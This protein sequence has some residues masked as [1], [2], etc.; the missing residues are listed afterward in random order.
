MTERLLDTKQEG[1][2]AGPIRQTSVSSDPELQHLVIDPSDRI[3]LLWKDVNYSIATQKGTMSILSDI[4][5]F[6]E[7]GHLT[8]IMGPSGSGKTTLLNVLA[9]RVPQQSKAS[10]EGEVHLKIGHRPLVNVN[11]LDMPLVS[12]YVEQHDALFALSTVRE[13]FDFVAKLR[14]FEL[15]REEQ[16]RRVEDV[17]AELGLTPAADT[18]VGS[19]MPG[20]RGVSGGER[21]RVG[22]GC[23]LLH[24]P[25]LL[26]LD[27]PTSGLD[28][29]Q[30]LQVMHTLKELASMG[31]TVVCSVHQPRSSIYSMFDK[32]VLLAGGRTVYCGPAGTEASGYFSGVGFPVP[33]SFNPADHFLDVIS[34]DQR[35]SE[36]EE[37]TRRVQMLQDAHANANTNSQP[38]GTRGEMAGGRETILAKIAELSQETDEEKGGKPA[39]STGAAMN[40]TVTAA[41]LS[42]GPDGARSMVP[43]QSPSS[44]GASGREPHQPTG[45]FKLAPLSVSLPLL[46]RRSW[47]ELTRDVFALGIKWAFNF[48]FTLMFGFVYF[49]MDFSETSLQDRTG[50]IFFLAMNQAFGATIGTAQAIPR[51]LRVVTRERAAKLYRVFP[52]WLSTF[53]CSLPLETLPQILFGVITYYMVN[54][55]HGVNHLFVFVAILLL[56][57]F[58]GIAI[59]MFLSSAITNV[60]AVP[61]VAPAVTIIFLMFSGFFLNEDSI[62]AVFSPLKYISFIRYAFQA[63]C[64]NELRDA[65]FCD[66]IPPGRPCIEGNDMLEGYLH[67]G[68]VKIWEN[69]IWL[70]VEIAG[71]NI[72]AFIVLCLRRPAFLSLQPPKPKEGRQGTEFASL[73]AI[74]GKRAEEM[75]RG[76]AGSNGKREGIS[77]SRD[78]E[79]AASEV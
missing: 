53:L 77:R 10:L 23:E 35:P 34:I 5:G 52:F 32:L 78:G 17:I 38:G 25:R 30:A 9:G 65:K 70:A 21:K 27:E 18:R 40:R 72:L 51:Q 57:N 79:V 68:N 69:A 6:A 36:K 54:L 62:P 49:R 55:R 76:E 75:S 20:Q 61:Q 2:S 13:T 29:F 37:T 45:T 26:F 46:L 11:D 63:L 24:R 22:L 44:S 14:L 3:S 8:A 12:A 56:E 28:S 42:G 48:F 64:V 60:E 41:S 15:P 31:H 66:G 50:I 73:A 16:K 47:K 58:V 4:T 7:A 19:D 67:F 71:F 43:S 39:G 74:D 1:F 59:G 33:S